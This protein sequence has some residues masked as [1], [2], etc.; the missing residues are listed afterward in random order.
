MTHERGQSG[1]V[2]ASLARLMVQVTRI[3]TEAEETKRR[4]CA[5]EKT[6]DGMDKKLDAIAADISA[7]KSGLRLGWGVAARMITPAG[8]GAAITWVATHMWGR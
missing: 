4:L 2:P 8:I 1:T 3:E 7:A 6:V 5:V